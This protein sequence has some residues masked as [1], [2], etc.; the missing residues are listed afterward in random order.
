MALFNLI[1]KIK[2]DGAKQAETDLKGVKGAAQ[3]TASSLRATAASFGAMAAAV[4]SA[5]FAQK[6][7]NAA[8]DYDSAVRALA[9]VANGAEDLQM[10]LARLREIAKAPGLGF[11]EAIIGSVRLQSAGLSAQLAEKSLREFAN[12]VAASG[13]GKEQLDG[14]TVALAQIAGKGKVTAEEINQIAERFYG[15]R[16]ALQGAF[17]T[18]DTEKIQKMNLSVEQFFSKLLGYMEKTP[19]VAGG[20]RNTLD[21]LGDA[22]NSKILVPLGQIQAAIFTAFGSESQGFIDAFGSMLG[23]LQRQSVLLAAGLTAVGTALAF[24][25]AAKTI[26]GVMT[27]VAAIREMV[28]VVRALG[29]AGA[30]AQALSTG[31]TSA[32]PAIAGAA[33]A[34]FAAPI[35]F[36]SL[37]SSLRNI[38]DVSGGL[39]PGDGPSTTN[40]GSATG[41]P[42]DFSKFINMMKDGFPDFAKFG[43]NIL[44]ESRNRTERT[45]AAIEKNTRDTSDILS[46]RKQGIGG[47]Q[48]AQA[49]VTAT[50]LRGF[51]GRGYAPGREDYGTRPASTELESIYR[52]MSRQ[53]TQRILR[54]GRRVV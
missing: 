16:T 12:A 33:A 4:A 41:G 45:L 35:L 40:L 18:S 47:G 1:A 54:R 24:M 53:E 31:G 10:Q 22:I 32:A 44:N 52:R 48:L 43:I 8:V 50:E 26:A 25:A 19:R 11:S 39:A 21:N 49:G 36:Q 5:S 27:L 20:L 38:K 2:V 34:A 9:T 30:I 7:F 51:G 6:A 28:V 3:E 46:L 23:W 42:G 14:I 17:G 13:G 37:E 15:I 29:V